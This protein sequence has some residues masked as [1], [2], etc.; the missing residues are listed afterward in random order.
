[1]T[2]GPEAAAQPCLSNGV[3][4]AALRFEKIYS[5]EKKKKKKPTKDIKD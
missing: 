1:V 3:F 2:Q 5:E 4:V